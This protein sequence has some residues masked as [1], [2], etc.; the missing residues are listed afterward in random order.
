M[1]SKPNGKVY[2]SIWKYLIRKI[3]IFMFL[4]HAIVL[5]KW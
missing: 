4:L 1:A 2:N 3:T 5:L